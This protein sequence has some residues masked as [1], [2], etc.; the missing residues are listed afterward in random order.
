MSNEIGNTNVLLTPTSFTEVGI[1]GLVFKTTFLASFSRIFES[2]VFLIA[3][4]F[5]SFPSSKMSN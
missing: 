2:V 3:F 5:V 4:K 1:H